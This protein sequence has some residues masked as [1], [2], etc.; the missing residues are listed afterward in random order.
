MVLA[1]LL[2]GCES[3]V[4]LAGHLKCLQTFI[5]GWL[6]VILGVS[7]WDRMRNTNLQSMGGLE[8]VEVM[9][10]RRRLRWLGHV[11]RMDV[12]RLPKRLLV[13]RTVKGKRSAPGQM[14]R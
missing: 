5:M 7:R 12:S 6:W 10:M 14:K 1:T 4:S 13:S 9:V 3:W 8:K 2:Y 11:E